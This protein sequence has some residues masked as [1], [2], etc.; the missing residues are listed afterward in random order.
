MRIGGLLGVLLVSAIARAQDSRLATQPAAPLL[1]REQLLA[2]LDVL[3]AGIV[4]KWSYLEDK[5]VN[6][7]V[8]LKKLLDRATS[9]IGEQATKAEFHDVVV[10]LVAGLKDGHANVFTLGVPRPQRHWPFEIAETPDGFVV[11]AQ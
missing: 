9:R 10:E 6:F 8:D 7:G 2:D 4:E 5:Q 11:V 1:T 3:A